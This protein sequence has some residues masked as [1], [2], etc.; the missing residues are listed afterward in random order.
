MGSSPVFLPAVLERPINDGVEQTVSESAEL[1]VRQSRC[2][3][4]QAS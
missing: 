3:G 1:S 4:D 2:F